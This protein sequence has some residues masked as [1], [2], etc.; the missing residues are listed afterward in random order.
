[1]KLV[2][3]DRGAILVFVAFALVTLFVLGT[4]LLDISKTDFDISKTQVARV[5][6]NY[7]A[8]SIF[9]QVMAQLLVDE[10]KLMALKTIINDLPMGGKASF[11][12][13]IPIIAEN[14]GI[15]WPN[16]KKYVHFTVQKNNPD[17]ITLSTEVTG[18]Y[19]GKYGKATKNLRVQSRIS[20]ADGWI[21]PE[22]AAI[23]SGSTIEYK[24]DTTITG[25]LFEKQPE[26][27]PNLDLNQFTSWQSPPLGWSGDLAELA[28]GN[29]Y[30]SS[31]IEFYGTYSGHIVLVFDDS[32]KLRKDTAINAVEQ[33]NYV[34]NSLIIITF[35]DIEIKKENKYSGVY[36]APYGSVDIDKAGNFTGTILCKDYFYAKKDFTI[37]YNEELANVFNSFINTTLSYSNINFDI[38]NWK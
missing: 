5:Q 35:G 15:T 7:N 32:V 18:N 10:D 8:E 17:D 37:T 25:E 34:D 26:L 38:V 30:C 31:P 20:L 21:L 9:N 16:P 36:L 6:A 14:G 12:L 19:S 4:F 2:K 23:V 3:N 22:D 13:S 27:I 24:K 28:P 11:D 33:D 29:Y 1:M